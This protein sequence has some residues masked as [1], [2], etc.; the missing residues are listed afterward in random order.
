MKKLIL[1]FSLCLLT[2]GIF[3]QVTKS[4][5]EIRKTT[6][7]LKLN[8]TGAI[9]NFYNGDVIITHSSNK[10]TITGGDL[11]VPQLLL[12]GATSGSTTLKAPA[13]AGT[14]V[15][16]LP[17]TS[18]TLISSADT[19]GMLS[20]YPLTSEVNTRYK[21]FTNNISAGAETDVTLV[22]VTTAPYSVTIFDADDWD[23]THAVKDSIGLSGGVY[24]VYIY[25]TDA[26]TNAK[27]KVLW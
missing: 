16:T 3:A 4:D 2:A 26:K 24:H 7:I 18:G 17:A 20:N 22:G 21:S 19:S 10:L 1:I 11:Q 15:I 14:A 12:P 25:S 5:I 6:P 23:M 13:I 27:I 9:I 8:G